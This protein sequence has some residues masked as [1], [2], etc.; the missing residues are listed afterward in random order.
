MV[1][2]IHCPPYH[3]HCLRLSSPKVSMILCQRHKSTKATTIAFSIGS[4]SNNTIITPI[5]PMILINN[6]STSLGFQHK[7]VPHQTRAFWNNPRS[8]HNIPNTS[9]SS[10]NT[11]FIQQNQISTVT[12]INSPTRTRWR[13]HLLLDYLLVMWLRIN[14]KASHLQLII[15]EWNLQLLY[16]FNMILIKVI[17]NF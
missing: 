5:S 7:L 2:N 9:N 14:F 17:T 6:L 16:H 11:I 4:N 12:P 13:L 1:H 15:K 10:D 3:N 8:F